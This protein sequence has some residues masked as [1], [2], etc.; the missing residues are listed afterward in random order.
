MKLRTYRAPTVEVAVKRAAAELGDQAVFVGSRENPVESDDKDRHEVTFALFDAEETRQRNAAANRSAAA[1]SAFAAGA[2]AGDD[3]TPAPPGSTVSQTRG[4]VL[5]PTAGES[6]DPTVDAA[7]PR[8]DRPHWKRFV[9]ADLKGTRAPI[10]E[11]DAPTTT[12]PFPAAAT[13]AAAVQPALAARPASSESPETAEPSAAPPTV[14]LQPG[15]SVAGAESLPRPPSPAPSRFL[16]GIDA[17]LRTIRRLITTELATRPF[18]TI[19]E[20]GYLNDSSRAALLTR[21]L[22]A[23]LDPDLCTL[24][25]SKL[26]Q[27]DAADPNQ[28]ASRLRG[29][30]AELFATAPDLDPSGDATLVAAFVGPHGSGKTSAALKLAIRLAVAQH[31]A[32]HLVALTGRRIGASEPA[33]TY[34]R[35]AQI[36]FTVVD[37]E[38]DLVDCVRSIT[39]AK[40]TPEIVLLDLPGY[41]DRTREQAEELAG[42]LAAIDNVDTHL[43]LD[44]AKKE[45]DRRRAIEFH[46]V[47][48][49]SKL[50]FTRLDQTAAYGAVIGDSLRTGL[51][52]GYLSTGPVIPDDIEAADADSIADRILGND[53]N[54]S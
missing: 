28:A 15:P 27:A 35:L 21:L 36:P 6:Q 51:P 31:R 2:G 33:A 1:T 49:P 50:L 34:A 29:G 17:E 30:L 42:Q 48:N 10:L 41:T 37:R 38:S 5:R 16:F 4:A 43:V 7:T 18:G 47:F 39:A 24:L 53:A 8:I 3:G 54:G 20:S 52:I 26:A 19:T 14:L 25:L 32:V 45:S 44:L 22:A 23:E 9:P 11:T 46:Q 40:P 13:S 12:S